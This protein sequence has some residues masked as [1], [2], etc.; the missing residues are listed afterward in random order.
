MEY[1]ARLGLALDAAGISTTMAMR[2]LDSGASADAFVA[3]VLS[4]R[5]ASDGGLLMLKEIQR[6]DSEDVAAGRRS[7]RSLMAFQKGDLVGYTLAPNKNS[8]FDHAG[9]GW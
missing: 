6:K 4:K 3:E 2:L 1:W 8:E 9:S 5:T 7:A